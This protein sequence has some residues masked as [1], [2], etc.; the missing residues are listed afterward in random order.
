[1]ADA[2]AP[3]GAESVDTDRLFAEFPVP[4][5]EQ[6]REEVIRLLK[7]AP[8]DKK[9]LSPTYEGITLQPIYTPEDVKDLPHMG[10]VPGAFPYVRGTEVLGKR[11]AGWL[12]AQEL[13]Y[14]TA[15]EFN[16]ALRHDLDRGQT[17]VNLVLDTASQ[18]G[19]DP[20][21]AAEAQVGAGGTSIGSLADLA[22]A[23]EGVDLASTPLFLT[24]GSSALATAAF[25]VAHLKATGTDLTQATLSLGFDPL[26]TLA[27][28]GTLPMPLDQAYDELAELTRYALQHL[29]KTR[30]LAVCGHPY[31]E[32]GANAV[33]ELAF[34]LA[35]AVD[36]LR[37]METRGLDLDQ[38]A[39]RFQFRLT[40]GSQFF[41]EIAKLRA[42]RL[43]WAQVIQACGGSDASAK[44]AL[45]ARTGR[46]N[47][48]Q[49][50]PHVNLLRGTTEAFSAVVGGADSLHVGAFDEVLGLPSDLGR[51]I[52]RN[53]QLMLREES[54]LDHVVDLAG[55][56]WYI[57]RLTH[58]LATAAW[59]LFQEVEGLGGMAKALETGFVQKGIADIAAA[60]RKA[61]VQRTDFILGTNQYA[62]A[63]ESLPDVKK[64]DGSKVL[65]LRA[66]TF[67]GGAALAGRGFEDLVAAASSASLG[68][69]VAALGRPGGPSVEAL[70][71]HRAAEVF[72]ILRK[73]VLTARQGGKDG[74]IFLANLG[75]VGAYMPRLDFT[76]GFFQVGGFEVLD[77]ASFATPAEAAAAAAEAGVRIVVA[78]GLDDTYVEAVPELAKALKALPNPPK[79]LVAGLL[80]DHAEA[81]KAAGVDDFIHV[82]SD[83]HAVLSSLG[84]T[85]EVF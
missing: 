57:E 65:A 64:V 50:D 58:E 61:I 40:V 42:A 52:A 38:V 13:P 49:F 35:T 28:K 68:Q 37:A 83:V 14:P 39:P 46:F 67:E 55:G 62:N 80:K 30:T 11:L 76:R 60:R 72:E 29:P 32:A 71:G 22:Q 82:R 25:V 23:L 7:G 48:T 79:V 63:G 4:S 43:L 70:R 16:E 17:A 85:L 26:G 27:G 24:S 78:V 56:S 36:A 12:V 20:H 47:K 15:A 45:H 73:A 34:T 3:C 19:L 8:Y 33:Q 10:G 74:R 1:M 44:M 21:Q 81:F 75:P 59:K 5:L 53:T 66:K 6:W 18:A 9:M 84:R 69:L 31:H 54:K 41:M 77:G 2:A 51:R